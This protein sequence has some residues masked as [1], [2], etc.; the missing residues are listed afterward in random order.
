MNDPKSKIKALEKAIHGLKPYVR[1]ASYCT[2]DSSMSWNGSTPDSDYC[3]CNLKEAVETIQKAL[4][5]K[6]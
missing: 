1:H 6:T 3:T 5:I 2:Y 4:A